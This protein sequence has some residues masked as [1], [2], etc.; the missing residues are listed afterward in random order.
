MPFHRRQLTIE[1]ANCAFA[2]TC[3]LPRQGTTGSFCRN[4]LSPRKWPLPYK[5]LVRT[6][7]SHQNA[8]P[9]FRSATSEHSPPSSSADE[10]YLQCPQ[11]KAL[12]QVDA[13]ELDSPPRV[14]ACSACLHEW[15]AA[16]ESLLWGDEAALQALSFLSK[17]SSSPQN[18]YSPRRGASNSSNR[19][20]SKRYN[21]DKQAS[22]NDLAKKS[23]G[24]NGTDDKTISQPFSNSETSF[25]KES[26]N[27]QHTKSDSSG[28]SSEG[29]SDDIIFSD[30]LFQHDSEIAEDS[31]SDSKSY[32][33]VKGRGSEDDDAA[34][35]SDT[36]EKSGTQKRGR[37]SNS[38]NAKEK[39]SMSIF[40][41]NLSFRATEEDLYRAFSG[42][43][44]VLNCQVP[45]DSCGASKGFGFVLMRERE[46]G[47]KAIEALHGTSILG[48]DI[49]LT[50]AHDRYKSRRS[51]G[52]YSTSDGKR[53]PQTG[54]R[55]NTDRRPAD[56]KDDD[57]RNKERRQE[58]PRYSG[59]REDGRD[60][61]SGPS[62]NSRRYNDEN[63][64]AAE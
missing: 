9:F 27:S 47:M 14:V 46:S 33:P 35:D 45:L 38:N 30:V 15:Y 61:P 59:Y 13:F 53:K 56:A 54:D 8:P 43:G 63:N 6:H 20:Q 2:S 7:F 19:F 24:S 34:G 26:K 36:S 11:C 32:K 16:E 22:D 37:N 58:G 50:E 17:E 49:T 23:F 40:V 44:L 12:Y 60:S 3:V 10:S 48:R 41:G 4:R 25:S 1:V 57:T 51:R 55:R 64:D 28:S 42:Y 29:L 62:R 21:N 39:S 52:V 31:G 18:T 5:P